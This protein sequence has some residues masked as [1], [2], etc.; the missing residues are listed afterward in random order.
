[1]TAKAGPRI[2]PLHMQKLSV[3]LGLLG[4]VKEIGDLDVVVALPNN[5]GLCFT[6][7][8]VSAF[9]ICL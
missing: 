5:L 7:I 1:M 6:C 4:A 3:G 8:D 9:L 2:E